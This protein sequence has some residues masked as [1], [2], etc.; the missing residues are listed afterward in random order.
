MLTRLFAHDRAPDPD[1]DA[2]LGQHPV[3]MIF[4]HSPLC[5]VS[6]F[7]RDEVERFSREAPSLPITVVDVIRQRPLSDG[8]AAR[9]RVRHESP[10]VLLVQEGQI[11]WHTS[12]GGITAEALS[13]AVV[14]LSG[15]VADGRDAS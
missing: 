1:L 8:I 2:I 12:H 7:A 13:Q 6:A 15:K 4:K 10:Q 11:R 3:Q 5:V 9:T 14:G